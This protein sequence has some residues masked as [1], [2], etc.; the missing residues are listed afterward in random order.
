MMLVHRNQL[1]SYQ[2]TA[3]GERLK[4]GA[5]GAVGE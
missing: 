1:A 4:K 3:Q 2:G 5:I